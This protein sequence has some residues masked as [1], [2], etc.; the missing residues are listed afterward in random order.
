MRK[1]KVNE[2]YFDIL[3]D[4][5]AYWLGFLYADGYVRMKDGRSGELKLKLKDTDKNHIEKFLSEIESNHSIK[6]GIDNKSKFCQERKYI[7]NVYGW[8]DVCTL[9]CIHI[10]SECIWASEHLEPFER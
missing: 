4:N 9:L 8:D 1:Y 5:S 10:I 2:S 6:C 3:N 7:S